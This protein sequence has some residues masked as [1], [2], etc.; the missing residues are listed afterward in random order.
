MTIDLY[1]P[2]SPA[3]QMYVYSNSTNGFRQVKLTATNACGNYAEDFVFLLESGNFKAYPNPAKEKITLEFGNPA[4]LAVMSTKVELYPEKS[5]KP[6]HSMLIKD[7]FD[8][9]GFREGNKLDLDVSKLPRGTYYLHVRRQD[10]SKEIVEKLRF[11]L[12]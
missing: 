11:I 4:M 7:L 8:D 12:E 1:T 2:N 3:T 10:H 9:K 6:V 5:A